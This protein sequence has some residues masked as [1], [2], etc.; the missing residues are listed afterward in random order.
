MNT[1]TSKI[2]LATFAASALATLTIGLA[3]PAIAAPSGTND[4]TVSTVSTVENYYNYPVTG[5]TAFGTYQN[6]NA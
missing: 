6:D 4:D 5:Q 2:T 1:L 3:A